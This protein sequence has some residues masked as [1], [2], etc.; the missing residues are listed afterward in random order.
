MFGMGFTEILMIAV[1]A[2][3]F[4]GPDKLPDA[5][6]QIA[7]F[8]N[9]FRKTINEAKNTFEEEINIKEL[10]EEALSYR[11]TL[12][13]AGKDI[14]G[15]KHSLD[16]SAEEVK[17]AFEGVKLE[18]S[19]GKWEGFEDDFEDL[20]EEYEAMVEEKQET[21]DAKPTLQGTTERSS[22]E[23]GPEEKTSERKI[24]EATP[25]P[26]TFKNLAGDDR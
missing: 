20:S 6:V 10:R 25:R 11:H 24:A 26:S 12:A 15:F 16:H 19:D 21:R 13:E 2:I 1:V 23:R 22:E 8:I 4:L 5:M 18:G 9:S 7:K 17:E 14:S 3:L